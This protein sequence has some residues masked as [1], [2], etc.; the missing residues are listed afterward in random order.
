MRILVVDDDEQQANEVAAALTATGYRVKCVV[1]SLEALVAIE[2]DGPDLVVIDWA[3]PFITGAI[4]LQ[5]MRTGLAHPP[6]VVVLA[7]EDVE[8]AVVLD[9]GAA[10][11]LTAPPDPH[12]LVRTVRTLLPE[13]RQTWSPLSS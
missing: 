6:P 10:A 13:S 9:A 7:G 3:M 12:S 11:C 5:V 1:D 4:I 8:Q 2:D